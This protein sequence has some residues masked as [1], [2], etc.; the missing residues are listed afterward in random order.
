MLAGFVAVMGLLLIIY[1]EAIVFSE[2]TGALPAGLQNSPL[3]LVAI[4]YS[5]ASILIVV[6][7]GAAILHAETLR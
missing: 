3:L 6:L 4:P 5:L 1:G 2:T 7:F